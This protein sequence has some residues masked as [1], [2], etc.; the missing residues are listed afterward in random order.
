MGSSDIPPPHVSSHVVPVCNALLQLGGGL[1]TICYILLTRESIK[2]Q[3]YG[4]PMFAL[5]FN[6]AW[7]LVY[8]LTVAEATLEKICF[9]IWLAIDCGLVYGLL[10]YG[11]NEWNHAPAVKNHLGSIFIV[12]LGGCV[13]GHWAFAKWWLDNGLGARQG[14]FYV[15]KDMGPDTTELGFWSAAVA[16][17]ILSAASLSQLL[18]RGHTGGV[19][20]SVWASRFLGTIVGLDMNYVWAWY[21]WREAHTYVMSPFAIFLLGTGLACDLAYPFVYLQV[22][23]TTKVL[24][25][26]RK[27]R[28]ETEHVSATRREK[29]L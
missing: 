15:G 2:S 12:L 16:Q 4:M 18:I 28:F 7:E 22:Q 17:L 8:A 20:W 29:H 3:S 19:T 6:F 27:I 1:W 5:A 25:G 21:F 14:K 23:K 13:V 9:G 26:G 24:D 11:H 10:K